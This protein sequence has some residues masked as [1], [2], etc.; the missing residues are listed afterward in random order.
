MTDIRTEVHEEIDRMTDEEVRGLQKYLATYPDPVAAAFRN[1]PIDD[2]PYTEE[3][4][5]LVAEADEWFAQNGGRGIPHE[6]V[7]REL[8]LE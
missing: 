4:Q 8:G 7:V 5:R 3:E 2:E 1:A 6:E